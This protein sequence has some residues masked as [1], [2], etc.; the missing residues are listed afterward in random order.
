MT[1]TQRAALVEK[2]G[3][4]VSLGSRDV[5]VPG[6][7][8]VLVKVIATMSM[9]QPPSSCPMLTPIV[10]PH[11]TYG[12]DWGLLIDQK[13]PAVLG[14]NV[15]GIVQEIGSGAGWNVGDR[16]F[17]ISSDVPSSSDQCGLQEYAI[18]NAN[19]VAAIPDGFSAEQVV[20]LP[21]NLVTS[22]AALFTRTGFHI[23]PPYLE[24]TGYDYA[25]TCVVVIGGG[26]NV[27]QLAVQLAHVAGVGKIVVVAGANNYDKLRSLG[28]TDVIDRRDENVAQQIKAVMGGDGATMVYCCAPLNVDMTIAT[29]STSMPSTLRL[30]LPLEEHQGEQIRKQRPLCDVAFIDDL[31]N[32]SLSPHAAR[33]WAKVWQWLAEGRLLPTEYRVIAGLEKVDEINGAL[34][35]Y[36]QPNRTNAQTV[37]R[38]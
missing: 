37:V 7:G 38:I 10:L 36:Q 28:A 34:D 25:R 23:A 3:Q 13:L 33:F 11:D 32:E 19:A 4:P 16:V 20:T 2:I 14:N 27:G 12:R 1:R 26:S 24:P 15:A 30:L 22:A 9:A 21:I 6:A 8:Q 35:E 29:L 5:P 31:T 18:L 17:G